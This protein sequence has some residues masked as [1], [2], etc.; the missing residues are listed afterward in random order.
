MRLLVMMKME[1]KTTERMR[2]KV[3]SENMDEAPALVDRSENLREP[4]VDEDGFTM[5]EVNVCILSL[6]FYPSS[7]SNYTCR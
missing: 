1:M 7:R 2:S 5:A 4:Q 6:V 3:Q